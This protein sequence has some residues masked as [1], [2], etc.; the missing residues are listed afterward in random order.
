MSTS[1]PNSLHTARAAVSWPERAAALPGED[2]LWSRGV[3]EVVTDHRTSWVRRVPTPAGPLFVKTYEYATWRSRLR[4]FGKRTGPFG[5]PRTVREFDALTWLRAQGFA[6]PTA[7]AALVWRRWGF[8]VRTTL[9]TEAFPGTAASE[10]LP[11]LSA[12]ERIEVAGALARFV[13]QLHARGF[14]DRNLDLRNLL[15][16]RADDGWLVAK[17]DSP[18]FVVRRPGAATDAMARADWRRL[19][20]QLAAFGLDAI[21]SEAAREARPSP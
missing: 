18:R 7:L 12:V 10:L 21:A 14:R 9:V 8:V 16:R 15:V 20:P 6:A 17:I 19:L 11:T 1:F 13:Q 2:Q 4:D 3:G 5:A